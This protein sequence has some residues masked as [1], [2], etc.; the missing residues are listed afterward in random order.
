MLQSDCNIKSRSTIQLYLAFSCSLNLV[1]KIASVENN[2][3]ISLSIFNFEF[4]LTLF[5]DWL[6]AKSSA[7]SDLKAKL[8]FTPFLFCFWKEGLT[9]VFRFSSQLCIKFILSIS[10]YI[11]C[12]I[13]CVAS[14][15]REPS[16]FLVSIYF[17]INKLYTN[18]NG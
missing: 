5:H 10:L 17:P 11:Y 13:N 12:Y 7:S 3:K 6:I 15:S 14:T 4:T 9:R 1:W 2:F 8:Q 16:L 18:A